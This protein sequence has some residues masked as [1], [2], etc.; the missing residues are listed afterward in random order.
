M[1][2][3]IDSHHSIPNTSITHFQTYNSKELSYEGIATAAKSMDEVYFKKGDFIIE[4]DTS[5]ETFFVLEAGVVIVTVST[6]AKCVETR[7]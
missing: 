2:L 6:K 4:Q 1:N 5:G 3:S 7:T